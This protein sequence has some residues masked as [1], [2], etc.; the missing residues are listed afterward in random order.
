VESCVLTFDGRRCCH[1][2][3]D[4]PEYDME[5]EEP[6]RNINIQN[7]IISGGTPDSS[8]EMA[9]PFLQALMSALEESTHMLSNNPSWQVKRDINII[10][11]SVSEVIPVSTLEM[12]HRLLQ[13]I[14]SVSEQSIHPSPEF[15]FESSSATAFSTVVTELDLEEQDVFGGAYP[16]EGILDSGQSLLL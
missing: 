1:I 10:T 12:A 4:A 2:Y 11:N 9:Q 16:V 6:R 15:K 8:M 3:K 7:N 5:S 13:A 14:V